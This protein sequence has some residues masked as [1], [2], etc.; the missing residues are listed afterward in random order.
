MES[1]VKGWGWRREPTLAVYVA[2]CVSED[3][4]WRVE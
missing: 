3:M 1:G 2:R 4:R